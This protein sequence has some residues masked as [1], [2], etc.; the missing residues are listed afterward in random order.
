[1]GERIYSLQ[2]ANDD[3]YKGRDFTVEIDP[4]TKTL[5]YDFGNG[6]YFHIGLTTAPNSGYIRQTKQWNK[7]GIVQ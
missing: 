5:K 7:Y 2:K 6:Q 3:I 1:M 4:K